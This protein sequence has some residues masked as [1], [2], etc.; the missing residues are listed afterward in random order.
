[1]IRFL[2]KD[3]RV[4]K[5]VFII[6]ISV[7]CIT[8]VITLVPGIF[9]DQAASAGTYATIRPGNP[10]MRIFGSSQ[11]IQTADVQQMAAR[12]LQ[13]QQL[14]EFVLPYMMQRVG[15]G[16]IQ[17][18]VELVEADR[19]GLKVSND[20]VVKFLHT[21]QFGMV[22]FPGGKYIGDQ[23]YAQLIN[24]NFGI[25]RERFETEIKKEIQEKRLQDLVTGGVTVSDAEVRST[26]VDQATKI[27]FDYAVV[28]AEDLR[29]TINPSDAELQ[30]FF[31][32]NAAKYATAV[33]ETR[34][35]AYVAFSGNSA[36]SSITPPTDA[37][38][39]SFYQQHTKDFTVEESAKVR[40]I[41]I[42]VDPAGGAAADAAAKAK[43]QGILDQLHKGGDFAAL[44]K[45]NS[46]DPGSKVQ[47]GELPPLKRGQ[48]VPEFDQASFSLPVGQLSGLIKTR[49]GYHILQVQDRQTAHTRPFDEVKTQIL[50]Q[51]TQQKEAAQQ[52]Q[53]AQTIAAEAQKNGLQKTAEA[54]HLQV[55]TTDY[56]GQDGVIG[57]LADGSKVLSGA[58]SASKG[59]APQMAST[60]DGF[61]IYQVTDIKGAHAPDFA[62]Y[63]DHILGDYREQ[64]LP[65]LLAKK[66]SELADKAHAENDLAKAAKEVGATFKSSDLVG[67]TAQVPDVGALATAAPQL[68]SLTVGQIST[69]IN[70]PRS[71]IVAKLTDKQPP[72]ADDIAKNLAQT[73]EGI[74]NE[75]KEEMFSVF[76]SNLT[77]TYK[78]AGRIVMNKSTQTPGIPGGP[79]S[80]VQPGS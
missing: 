47:G 69:P 33:P 51:L 22:L 60:G 75:R 21:G 62:A 68:F 40:H 65:S 34:K 48:T 71:G 74:V 36:P 15:Q 29:K 32:Q 77:D 50:A 10:L 19:L 26:F 1:M 45:A 56:V 8:M 58:F 23:A 16:M 76:V 5:A 6:I 17:Q 37:E 28:S 66:T 38:L 27:K 39:H 25:S 35:I 64:Q 79:G 46:D 70:T 11:E 52:Q 42:K 61:A 31:K 12:M 43:A 49:F 55:Q 41:L 63:K 13:R 80:P 44:A 20:A 57:G 67:R 54:H 59:A 9:Q 30:T 24:D 2:Q 78:K 18:Q 7:A 14:P 72:T 4:I 3:N 73:R 53:Y